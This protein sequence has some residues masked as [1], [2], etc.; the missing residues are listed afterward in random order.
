MFYEDDPPKA[1]PNGTSVARP[2]ADANWDIAQ[3]P[4]RTGSAPARASRSDP[5]LR[6]Q[7]SHIWPPEIAF[8][9][10]YGVSPAVL[11]SAVASAKQQGISADAALLAE[12]D[13]SE[14]HFYRSL[15]RHVRLP[16]LD[17]DAAI[18]AAARYPQAVHAG[19]APLA[20]RT[21]PAFLAAPRGRAITH[22]ILSAYRGELQ[23][24]LGLTT[25]TH[26]S[27]LLRAAFRS[28]ILHDASFAL[29]TLEPALSAMG[30]RWR[31]RAGAAAGL[32]LLAL[33]TMLD[34]TGTTPFCAIGLGLA[35]LAMVVLRIMACAAALEAIPGPRQLLADKDLPVY[36]IVIALYREARMVP[37]LVAALDKLDYPPAKLDIK[38]VIEEDDPETLL[39]LNRAIRPSVHEILVA[40]NSTLRTKPRALNVALPLLRGRFVA[41][42]DAE[43]V[44]APA[45]VR[46]AAERFAQAPQKLA[47]LQAKLAIDNLDH[48]WLPRLFALEYAALFDVINIGLADLHLPFPL[49]GSSNHFRTDILRKLGGWDAWNVT[50]DADIGFRFARFG[51]RTETLASTTLEEAPATLQSFIGQRRRWCKGWYQTLWTLCRDPRRLLREVGPARGVSMFLILLSNVLVPLGTPLGALCL[52]LIIAR[53]GL[54]WPSTN[55]EI[56]AATLWTSVFFGGVGAILGP[57][58]LGM[59]RRSLL[60]LWPKLL[61]LPAYYAL[62]SFAAWMGLYDLAM[63]PYHWCKTEHGAEPRARKRDDN[64]RTPI[65]RLRR[66]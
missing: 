11:S 40:P 2:D 39:A 8:L 28:Q 25:P 49:G 23:S 53:G 21:G 58:F 46:M 38:F 63:R 30:V 65:F 55:L 14:Y 34:V 31:Q 13:V 56:G 5:R 64:G 6:S 51:Y 43:D 18:A 60:P 26:F 7:A 37:R 10:H 27:K 36:S 42:F 44:P 52:G 66:A 15:A 22:L 45:Q 3:A 16:F 24:R 50:E 4:G 47:C 35:F 62:I 33:C 41:I 12:S 9:T 59:K 19:L 1:G 57:L 20:A 61:L 29:P 54:S 32:F 17:Q 48:G